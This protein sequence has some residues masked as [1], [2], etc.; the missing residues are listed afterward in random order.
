MNRKLITVAG[1]LAVPG[2]LWV[3]GQVFGYGVSFD[4]KNVF[5]NEKTRGPS[6]NGEIH[7]FS[8]PTAASISFEGDCTVGKGS[9]TVS[10][11]I[12][13]GLS[14]VFEITNYALF[15]TAAAQDDS[16]AIANSVESVVSRDP[17]IVDPLR[18]CWPNETVTGVIVQAVNGPGNV[19]PVPNTTTYVWSGNVSVH[20]VVLKVSIP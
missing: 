15:A 1:A 8:S 12:Q 19:D 14:S 16:A 5:E 13:T 7:Y 9:K 17:V 20:G 18:V 3:A 10:Y 11:H 2:I 4:R 6:A